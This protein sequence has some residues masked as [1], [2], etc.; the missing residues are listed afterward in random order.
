ML[1]GSTLRRGPQKAPKR[2]AAQVSLAV[3]PSTRGASWL[4]SETLQRLRG[5]GHEL[6]LRLDYAEVEGLSGQ[7]GGARG[8]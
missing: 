7:R 1:R 4:G 6:V 8:D 3:M 5:Q 2:A